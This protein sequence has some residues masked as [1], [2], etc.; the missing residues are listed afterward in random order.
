MGDIMFGDNLKK[1]RTEKGLT[2]QQLAILMKVGRSTIAGYETKGTQ[3]DFDKLNWLASY[4]D[5]N[6]DYLLGL[7]NMRNIDML[8]SYNKDPETIYNSQNNISEEELKVINYYNRLNDENKDYI[9]G[10]MIDLY[11]EQEE[12]INLQRNP[13]ATG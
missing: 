5:V 11:I 8:S 4:F 2:Q 6:I 1:L 10:K 3:P 7:S 9:K 13:T 12:K